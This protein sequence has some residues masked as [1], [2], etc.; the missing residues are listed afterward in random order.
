MVR[1][2]TGAARWPGWTTRSAAT[3]VLFQVAVF[4]LLV[5]FINGSLDPASIPSRILNRD[6]RMT[7]NKVNYHS[8][9][10]DAA[11]T[12][13]FDVNRAVADLENISKT[14]HSLNDMRSIDVRDYLRKTIWNIIKGSS[15]EFS[16]PVA[17]GTAAEFKANDGLVYWEDSSLVVRVP[18]TGDRSEALLVQAHYDAVPMSHGAFD[19][20]VGVVVCLELLRSLVSQP[21]RHPVLINIDWGEENGLFGATLF[22]RF[23]PWAESVRAYVNL[24]TGGVGGRAMLFRASHQS[25]L[26]AYKQA[27]SKPY[28]SLVGNDA[29]KLGIV[30]SDTDYSV[31]TTRYGIPGL[32]FAFAN[33]RT[34]YHTERDNIQ[35]VT[36]ESVLSMGV[37]TLSTARQIADSEHILPTLP[38]SP[39]L[40]ERPRQISTVSRS[41]I[42]ADESF[43][44]KRENISIANRQHIVI[45]PP[46]ST[47]DDI[48]EDVVFYDVLS[49][50]MVVRSYSAELLLNLLTGVIGFV[51]VVAVQYPF[52]RALPGDNDSAELSELS[53]TERLVM[54]LGRGGFFGSMLQALAVLVRAYLAGIFGSLLFTGIMISLVVPRLAYTHILLFVL[55]LFSAA[56]LSITCVLSA[57]ACRTRAADIQAMVWYAHCVFRCLILLLVVVPLNWT[58]IGILYLDQL[59]TWAAI[60]AALFTALI[61]T[62]NILGQMWRRWICALA[63]RLSARRG[64]AGN[65]QERLLALE[66]S[67][68]DNDDEHPINNGASAVAIGVHVLSALRLIICVVLPLAA[69][70]DVMLRL[71]VVLKD[72]L[73]DGSP[74]FACIAIAALHIVTFVMML[75][76]YIIDVVKN[77][78][79][80][81]LVRYM[82]TIVEPCFRLVSIPWESDRP[83]FGAARIPSRSQISLHTNH[84]SDDNDEYVESDGEAYPRVIDY[85]GE[86]SDSD[87]NER[88][89]L[90]G[91]G[92]RNASTGNASTRNS[93]HLDAALDSYSEDSDDELGRRQPRTLGVLKGESP[94]TVGMRMIYMWAGIW[95]ALWVLTQLVML[96]GD[97]YND[98]D[99][100][101][102]VR[103]FHSTRIPAECIGKSSGVESECAVSRLSLS[104]P[105]SAGLAKLVNIVAPSELTPACF[106][107]STRGFFKC[108][109]FYNSDNLEDVTNNTAWSPKNAITIANISHTIEPSSHGTRFNVALSFL[110]PET[111]TCFVD[112]GS[113]RGYS[114]QAYPNPHPVPPPANA[115]RVVTGVPVLTPVISRVVLPVIEHAR[116]VNHTLDKTAFVSEPISDRD[117]V[118][119]GRI[120]A[121]K[122][123]FDSA[124]LFTADIQYSVP[125]ENATS[126]AR[127]KVDISCYFDQADRH[128]PLLASIIGTAPKWA[129]FTP[130]SN[131][132][133][134]VTLVGLEI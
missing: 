89:I 122:Q 104:S 123:D 32:D 44:D 69:G 134:T 108:N 31:Y 41:F 95:L 62:K 25:L 6:T 26:Q 27:V 17:N 9:S 99:N 124:G 75:A 42:A 3:I 114:P 131:T 119:S 38:R 51:V 53:P 61:D 67:D 11:S 74:P 88:V 57:W 117:P 7:A 127:L 73:A 23:H 40:P 132:L 97:G 77:S 2:T 82:N 116:F 52:M 39:R 103:V 113:H 105:D 66:D 126:S 45:T 5:L 49:W 28:A 92:D 24:E 64:T 46:T 65:H 19:D 79:T 47:A 94:E 12:P 55:L 71:L 78:D 50:F 110:A 54:Q 33:H 34:L 37:A 76:P 22:A 101:L 18:G 102:K 112:F 120:L 56:A 115:S 72:H 70:M 121:H 21:T 84:H 109:F 8:L 13:L 58:G 4:A 125:V 130:D 128:T 36:S 35:H 80:H 43:G 86:N 14:P 111:R 98:S 81:W 68:N 106:S 20:G 107:L 100:P 15:A 93:A 60:T 85:H 30:K 90:L 59:Y 29:F 129:V 96:A 87:A 48:V 83:T 1:R 118:F 91:S 16:D 133:S 63:T 10:Q